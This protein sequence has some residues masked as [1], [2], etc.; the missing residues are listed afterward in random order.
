M[1]AFTQRKELTNRQDLK[2][3]DDVGNYKVTL[4]LE[5]VV[6]KEGQEMSLDN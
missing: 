3:K 6:R 2:R 1:T 4:L 5:Q